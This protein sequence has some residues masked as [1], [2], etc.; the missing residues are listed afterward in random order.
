M[1]VSKGAFSVHKNHQIRTLNQGDGKP[2]Q[3]DFTPQD[4]IDFCLNCTKED[5]SGS[6]PELKEY[7]YESKKTH[8]RSINGKGKKR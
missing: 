5:C 2:I 1:I 6:C 4:V 3:L 8:N 7:I